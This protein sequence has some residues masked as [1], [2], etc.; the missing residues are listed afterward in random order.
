MVSKANRPQHILKTAL[1]LAAEAPWSSISLRDIAEAASVSLSEIYTL[2]PSKIAIV[3]AY[4][5]SVDAAVLETKFG[6]EADFTTQPGIFAF[7]DPRCNNHL[8][9]LFGSIMG[10]AQ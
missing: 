9:C 7:K 8:Y 4:F 5:I 1:G 6:F 2:Y 3:K 10:F